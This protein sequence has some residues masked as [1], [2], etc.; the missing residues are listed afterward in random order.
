MKHYRM[1]LAALF[2]A[3][4]AVTPAAAQVR[5]LTLTPTQA[6]V[7]AGQTVD[8]TGS[9]FEPNE[10]VAVWIT[11]PEQIVLGGQYTYASKTGDVSFGY[12]VPREAVSGRWALTAHG[13]ISKTPVIAT[14]SVTGQAPDPA[15]Y[16]IA[17]APTSAP[18]GTTFAFAATGFGKKEKIS[19]WFTGPDNIVHASFSQEIKT[20]EDGRV[21]ISWA[22]PANAPKGTWVITIQGITS[23]MARAVTFE[24][25]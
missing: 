8:F 16:F 4:L 3:L 5:Q 7:L 18:A 9:G 14:F 22:S 17:A 24:I 15:R 10:R 23:K 21:D 25:K 20:N 13:D 12:G 2:L 11:T 6:D 1:I 19:Y